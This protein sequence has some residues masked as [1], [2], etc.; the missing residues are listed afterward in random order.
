MLNAATPP[1]V[2]GRKC[3][4]S[5]CT[6]L[7]VELRVP[8][9]AKES[10]RWAAAECAG[11][12]APSTFVWVEPLREASPSGQ[13]ADGDELPRIARCGTTS[14]TAPL[15]DLSG[16]SVLSRP[17]CAHCVPTEVGRPSSASGLLTGWNCFCSS[18][19]R[20]GPCKRAL[21]PPAEGRRATS[22]E[23]G[24]TRMAGDERRAV[25]RGVNGEVSCGG[26]H[27]WPWPP[28]DS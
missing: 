27:P 26:I 18:A 5:A 16:G 13:C 6:W 11:P 20:A 21:P 9:D 14:G 7:E 25:S 2:F 22:G 17:A 4:A 15:E 3:S 10:T 23:R 24:K 1:M 8:S 28:R 12:K 19:R